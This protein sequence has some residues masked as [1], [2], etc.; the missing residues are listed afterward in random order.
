MVKDLGVHLAAIGKTNDAFTMAG[1]FPTYE[2]RLVSY[3][4]MAD[5]VYSQNASP[6][7]FVF[8]DSIYSS[9]RRIDFTN[10]K[11]D[12]DCRTD[13]I[14]VL[15]KIGS[16]SLNENAV[17]VLREIPQDFKFDGVA[18]RISGIASE[19]NYYNARTSIPPSLTE[20]QDLICRAII[21]LED[22]RAKERLT[23]NSFWKEYD[24]YLEWRNIYVNFNPN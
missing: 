1:V 16:R 21:L 15:S 18:S 3:E 13:Q 5:K 19:G 9:G 8:L 4:N 2:L 17:E 14:R 24:R 22:C 20:S 10:L 6:A 11:L 23:G 12:F 7:T